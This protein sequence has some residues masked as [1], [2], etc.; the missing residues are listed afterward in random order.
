VE[1]LILRKEYWKK[2]SNRIDRMFLD[3]NLAM[4]PVSLFDICMIQNSENDFSNALCYFML[5]P[6]YRKIWCEFF[7]KYGIHLDENYQITREESAKIESSDSKWKGKKSGG[8]IDLLI[9]DKSSS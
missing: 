3:Q 1:Q 4:R 5:R 9:R 6:E 8:R 7:E 2:S